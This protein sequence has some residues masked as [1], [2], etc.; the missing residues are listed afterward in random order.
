[1]SAR[2][3]IDTRAPAPHRW[4]V[5]DPDLDRDNG[6]M[7]AQRIFSHVQAIE[8]QQGELREQMYRSVYMYTGERLSGVRVDWRARPSMRWRAEAARINMVESIA[9]TIVSRFGVRDPRLAISTRGGDWDLR[10]RALGLSQYLEGEKVRQKAPKV[11]Q[12]VINHGVV[13]GTGVAKV[14][15]WHDR[16][17]F[18]GI[19]PMEFVVDERMCPSPDELPPV[20]YQRRFVDVDQAVADLEDYGADV[21]EALWK[22]A[23]DDSQP[24]VSYLDYDAFHVPLI[25]AWHPPL[26]P[27]GVGQHALVCGNRVIFME[28]WP[29]HY[30]PFVTF[31]WAQR[32]AGWYGRSLPEQ[33][34]WI[35]ARLN[36]HARFEERYQDLA[37]IPRMIV[38]TSDRELQASI[39]NEL[40]AIIPANMPD[41]VK[42]MP[43]PQVSGEIYRDE[44]R[45]IALMQKV[46]GVN[47]MS[48]GGRPP[49]GVDSQPG[50]REFIDYNTGRHAT[51]EVQ[52]DQMRLVWADLVID[53]A[54]ELAADGVMPRATWY[55][56]RYG[57]YDV[58]WKDVDMDRDAYRLRVLP[59][60]S[61]GDTPAGMRQ[62]L[63]E[64]RASGRLAD[65]LYLYLVQTLD[66]DSHYTLADAGMA[67]I[68]R[69]V[70]QLMRAKEAF[71]SPRPYGPLHMACVIV[72]MEAQRLDAAGAPQ[73]ILDRFE[74]YIKQSE[75]LEQLGMAAPIGQ[76]LP[77]GP[78]QAGGGTTAI[79]RAGGA[80]L[81]V[82]NM[83]L[84][85]GGG[86]Q[87]QQPAPQANLGQMAM[88]TLGG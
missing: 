10:E 18:T 28:D 19:F 80:T 50:Q 72:Q 81:A 7:R 58:E 35:Q 77:L 79:P 66:V 84:P 34:G 47:E 4:W 20:V 41:M 46:S 14:D 73:V 53:R 60:S 76:P 43:T 15:N 45:K 40:G 69:D 44:D 82:A 70:R 74:A 75:Y 22:G 88:P 11:F 27:D 6:A 29:Y 1:M 31:R 67:L 12:Q 57:L 54:R 32:I 59:A 21:V 24:W 85:P 16:T 2:A 23:K 33:V 78:A 3:A 5:N 42:W 37:V 63:E 51:V 17:C 83:G 87:P 13:L 86:Q 49:P 36:R 65:D 61:I 26:T 64:E 62:R 48:M 55:S 68:M 52:V 9:N 56:A 8:E 25:E 38:H 30:V 71:P 39:T